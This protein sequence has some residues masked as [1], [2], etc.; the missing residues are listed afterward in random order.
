MNAGRP[1]F[2]GDQ[3]ESPTTRPLAHLS[4]SLFPSAASCQAVGSLDIAQHA[5]LTVSTSLSSPSSHRR[6]GHPAPLSPTPSQT[7]L[8]AVQTAGFHNKL[9]M[10]FKGTVM[11]PINSA[12]SAYA[13]SL[14]MTEESLLTNR[15]LLRHMLSYHIVNEQLLW[16]KA[17]PPLQTFHTDLHGAYLTI[18]KSKYGPVRIMY[19]ELLLK[20]NG[21][22]YDGFASITKSN[23]KTDRGVMHIIDRVLVPPRGEV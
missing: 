5:N 15:P 18:Y 22:E 13:T 4:L 10:F 8:A 7:F 2:Q 1:L 3:L 17:L 21:F 16:R 14:N 19:G 9:N 20:G 6:P 12:W 11:A 23:L